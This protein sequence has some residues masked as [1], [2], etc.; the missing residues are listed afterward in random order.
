MGI[1]NE[2]WNKRPWAA[3][4]VPEEVPETRPMR[5]AAGVT[6]DADEDQ[7]RPLTGDTKRD[8]S[9]VT[10][11]RMREMAVYLWESN[12]LANRLI[13]LPLAYL[14]GEGVSLHCDDEDNQNTLD[15]FWSDPINLM[16]IKLIKKLRELALYG[17]QCYPAFVNEH[18]GHV[19]LGYLDPA[20]IATVVV[21][22]DNAEQPIG[23]VTCKDRKG[24]ARRYKVI[25]NGP[26]D[27]LFTIRT[28]QIRE[29]FTDGEAFYFTINDLSNG[30]RGRSD[31]LAQADWQDGYEQFLYGELDRAQFLRAFLWDVTMKGATPQEVEERAKKI[32]PPA[33]GSVRVHND[34]EEWKAETPSL[35]ASDNSETARLF[36][37]HVL[38]GATI[39]EHWFGGGGDVNRAVGAEMGEPT[40][41]IFSMRQKFA[42]YMLQSIGQ[43]VL[44][45]KALAAGEKEPDLSETA[46]QVEARFPEMTARDTS[47]YASAL[48]QVVVACGLA[49]EKG[50]ITRETALK[51]I[52][53]IAGQLGIE[54]DVEAELKAVLKAADKTKEDDAFIEP[55]AAAEVE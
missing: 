33:P 50:F 46:Y 7:W 42:K 14:L 44:R 9:P 4:S 55:P 17:E 53:T 49:V 13:E 41:K 18:N 45:Q 35:Q 21:D 11:S 25:V 30:R 54:I 16:D 47:K 28:Q 23:I 36:R 32:T 29:T 40:F 51:V 10:Q 20:L 2:W 12:L 27:E 24:I 34:S 5:E 38:G 37:N 19:R 1:L 3:V 39:P 48:Q 31:L 26:D 6:I 8:L 22:P 15:R 52:S 43:Y